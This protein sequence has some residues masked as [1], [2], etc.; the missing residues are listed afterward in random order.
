MKHTHAPPHTHTH[1]HTHTHTNAAG[2][3]GAGGHGPSSGGGVS[4]SK[5]SACIT[6]PLHPALGRA[7]S[8]LERVFEQKIIPESGQ[9]EKA[10]HILI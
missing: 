6:V 2:D 1:W 8:E 9:G 4:I 7:F 5:I 10:T 3:G